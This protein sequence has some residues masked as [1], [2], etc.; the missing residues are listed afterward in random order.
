MSVPHEADVC[1]IIRDEAIL[2]R[3]VTPTVLPRYS[4]LILAAE[5]KFYVSS[6]IGIAM[7]RGFMGLSKDFASRPSFFVMSRDASRVKSLLAHHSE[8]WGATVIPTSTANVNRQVASF[9]SVFENY[10]ARR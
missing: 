2:C 10:K 5:C 4:S 1:V 6:T 3:A 9:E 8:N 7:G